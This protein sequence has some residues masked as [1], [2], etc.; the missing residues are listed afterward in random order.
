[1][2]ASAIIIAI[3]KPMQIIPKLT[4]EANMCNTPFINMSN[5]IPPK[6]RFVKG[7]AEIF[8]DF[9]INFKK[10]QNHHK[11]IMDFTK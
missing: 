1:M 4:A 6:M 8:F 3:I 5:I 10:S 2:T 11:D 7:Y 9:T